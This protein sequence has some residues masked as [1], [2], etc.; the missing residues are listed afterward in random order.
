MR[1]S[2]VDRSGW[3]L[4]PADD[5]RAPAAPRGSAQVTH[6]PF[7]W[8]LQS[9]PPAAQLGGRAGSPCSPTRSS[10]TPRCSTRS[11]RHKDRAP[12]RGGLPAPTP[13]RGP[14]H[15][16]RTYPASGRPGAEPSALA[17]P[18]SRRRGPGAGVSSLPRHGGSSRGA[19]GGGAGGARRRP[20]PARVAQR[21][22]WPRSSRGVQSSAGDT[23]LRR[24]ADGCARA[25]TKV[26]SVHPGRAGGR[27]REGWG[28]RLATSRTLA[29]AKEVSERRGEP[30]CFL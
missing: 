9:S 5:L 18:L 30:L 10:S 15:P 25:A 26:T 29:E 17:V 23:E 7:R 24:S 16:P 8:A 14:A 2:P 27:A 22:A 12:G 6:V 13:L 11:G 3:P 28:L 21:L 20:G 4:N 19:R 1:S